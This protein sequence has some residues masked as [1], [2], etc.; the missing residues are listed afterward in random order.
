MFVV[1]LTAL[2]FQPTQDLCNSSTYSVEDS[3]YITVF[4]Q[5][6]TNQHHGIFM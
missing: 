2:R 1:E 3:A 5:L 6:S 4:N